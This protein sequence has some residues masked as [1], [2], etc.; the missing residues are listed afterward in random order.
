MRENYITKLKVTGLFLIPLLP[1]IFGGCGTEAPVYSSVQMLP[2]GGTP[3]G[4]PKKGIP[5][6]VWGQNLSEYTVSTEETGSARNG[7]LQ[8]PGEVSTGFKWRVLASDFISKLEEKGIVAPAGQITKGQRILWAECNPRTGKTV[9]VVEFDSGTQNG[10]RMG[11]FVSHA[12]WGTI[13][14]FT[15]P[16]SNGTRQVYVEYGKSASSWTG[17]SNPT[18]I[19]WR[20]ANPSANLVKLQSVYIPDVKADP[21]AKMN[22]HSGFW[23][24]ELPPQAQASGAKPLC[25]PSTPVKGRPSFFGAGKF[26]VDANR[27]ASGFFFKGDNSILMRHC[28]SKGNFATV[29]FTPVLEFVKCTPSSRTALHLCGG[30][31][32]L[33][34]P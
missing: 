19:A 14:A 26:P 24:I 27:K 29:E 31:N 2:L 22:L 20:K 9:T 10:R 6:F 33:N 4:A 8:K 16:N 11:L 1:T 3:C 34:N 23:N 13:E 7:V 21:N 28:D 17:G 30:T 32:I 15:L 5:A 25:A 12:R 18:N